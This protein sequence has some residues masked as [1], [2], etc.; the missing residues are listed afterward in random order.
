MAVACSS[1]ELPNSSV[2]TDTILQSYQD[3]ALCN[4]IYAQPGKM[5]TT[6]ESFGGGI[7]TY[8]SG[9][10]VSGHCNRI[11]EEDFIYYHVGN[12]DSVFNIYLK[13]GHG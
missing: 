2:S 6:Y 9:F 13:I 4:N 10:T 7:F 3:Y 8:T 12:L 1:D 5:T 11:K